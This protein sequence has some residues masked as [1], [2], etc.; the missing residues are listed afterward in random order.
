MKKILFTLLF[1][2][3]SIPSY[4]ITLISDEETESWLEEIL[5]PIFKE[6]NIPFNKNNIH[7]IKDDT[8]NAFVGDSNH[9]FI[10]TG[11]LLK[12]DNTNQIEGVL[13]HETGHIVGGHILRLKIKIE[14]LQKA[15]LASS[16]IH[17]AQHNRSDH[18][19]L[20]RYT[21]D[22]DHGHPKLQD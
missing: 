9:M 18:L 19:Q 10:H 14:E 1:M 15:S 13:A 4:A 6:A 2:L 5:T 7:I 16:D 20:N 21:T 11:T 22:Y 17:S 8:L 3:M 12:A